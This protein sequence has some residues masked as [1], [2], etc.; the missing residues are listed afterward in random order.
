MSRDR[1]AQI[2]GSNLTNAQV[3]P[4]LRRIVSRPVEHIEQ[5]SREVYTYSYLRR[6]TCN[7]DLL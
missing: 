5:A 3:A 4:I 2:Y 1:A 6:E 7:F